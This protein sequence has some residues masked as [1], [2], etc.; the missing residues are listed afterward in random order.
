MAD[1][2]GNTHREIINA[3]AK[4]TVKQIT[5]NLDKQRMLDYLIDNFDVITL[6]DLEEIVNRK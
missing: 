6:E 2:F 3:E 4:R 5:D 1:L